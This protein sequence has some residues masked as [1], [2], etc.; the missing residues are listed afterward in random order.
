MTDSDRKKIFGISRQIGMNS[1]ELH[2]LIHGATGKDSIKELDPQQT[3]QVIS[4]LN[5]R[6]KN[7]PKR[8]TDNIRKYKTR[9]CDGMT[10]AQCKKAFAQICRL[11]ELD[12]R[13]YSSEEVYARLSGAIKKITGNTMGTREEPFYGLSCED[14]I[15]IIEKLKRYIESAEFKEYK[16]RKEAEG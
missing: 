3:A 9:D 11:M 2:F 1:D 13:L 16:A 5:M 15:A 4:E 14:G 7:T 6:L 12:G 8:R 10:Q